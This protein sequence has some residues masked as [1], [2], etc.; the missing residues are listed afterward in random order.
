MYEVLGPDPIVAFFFSLL[1]KY[2]VAFFG[3]M[4]NILF[5]CSYRLIFMYIFHLTHFFCLYMLNN[6]YLVN[7]S[8]V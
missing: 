7:L 4:T 6:E 3:T 8:L 2:T 1:A 5:A